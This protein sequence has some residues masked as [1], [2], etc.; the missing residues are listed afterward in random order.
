MRQIEIQVPEGH[1]SEVL[2]RAAEAGAID[3]Y[4]TTAAGMNSPVEVVRLNIGNSQVEQLTE[5]LEGLPQLRISFSPSGVLALRPPESEAAEQV[6][7]VEPRS[8]LEVFLSGLQSVGSWPSF[9]GYAVAAGIVVWI[10]LFTETVYLLT[11]AML[12]APFASPAMTA[13]LATARGD[14]RLFGRSL[15]RYGAA[16]AVTIAAAFLLSLAMQQDIATGMMVDRSLISSVALLLPVVAGAA[17]ALNLCQSERSSLVTG[18]A[19]GML[20]AASLAP[21]AGVVGMAAAIGEWGMVASAA[22]VLVAQIVG[23]NLSGAAVFRLY[24]VRPQG[25]RF[26]RGSGGTGLT[27]WFV[28]L[29]A[30]AG[31]F[32][33]QLVSPPNLQRSS[34]AQRATQTTREV[35]TSSGLG[36][37]V[38]VQAKFTR[39][40]I[41]GQNT[42][43][44]EAYV[45]SRRDPELVRRQ[46]SAAI[47]RKLSANYNATPLV[48][49]TVLE[50]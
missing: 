49:I 26:Q 23:I 28:S 15:M 34:L 47:K 45:Q 13:A 46:V 29:A 12:I 7:D 33:L 42:L 50:P 8:P 9:I 10:G 44:V 20:V 37:P 41:P 24:G 3:M 5:S 38:Q 35:I 48:S 25:V 14:M 36:E 30:L 19:T 2:R 6:V 31:L 22:F 43:L 21:P 39:A 18:A 17:G 40:D 1:G 32:T 11:A 16:L 4:N 27:L